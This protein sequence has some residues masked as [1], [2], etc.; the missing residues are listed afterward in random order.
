MADAAGVSSPLMARG[1][2]A[3]LQTLAGPKRAFNQFF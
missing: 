3:V 2:G 1:T